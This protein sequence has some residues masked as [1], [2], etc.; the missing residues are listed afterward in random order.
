MDVK[1]SSLSG[2]IK[3]SST[4]KIRNLA[5][6]LKEKGIPVI[7]FAAGEL[8]LETSSYIKDAAVDA[9]TNKSSK[10][11]NKLGMA[12]LRHKIAELV[13]EK[14]GNTYSIDNIAVTAG[15]KPAL[16]NTALTLFNEGDDCLLYTSPSPRDRG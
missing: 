4:G 11:T 14:T 16:Y 13:S 12:E 9:V 3:T 15:A 2:L 7:N 8:D 1:L 6:E 5:N 10:Y